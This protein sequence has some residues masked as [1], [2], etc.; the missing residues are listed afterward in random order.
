[1]AVSIDEGRSL[2]VAFCKDYPAAAQLRFAVRNSVQELYGAHEKNVQNMLG[3]YVTGP[4]LNPGQVHIVCGQARDTLDLTATLRNEILGHF[5]LNT[6]TGAEKRSV[7][8]ALIEARDQPVL[9]NLWA[10][11]DLHYGD[12]SKTIRAEEVFA[13]YCEGI[14]PLDHVERQGI[15]ER[16]AFALRETCVDHNRSLT[17]FDLQSL[18][19]MVA[20]G[21]HDGSRTQQNFPTEREQFQQGTRKE[22]RKSFHEL[23]AE[24]LIEQMKAG[25]APWQKPWKPG[26]PNTNIPINPTTGRRYRG[27]NAVNLMA[28]GRS[29]RRWMT[30]NQAAA[31]DAQVRKGEKGTP[32]Q[33]WKVAEE[34]PKVDDSGRPMLDEDGRPVLE[35]TAF[36]RPRVFFAT[37]FNAEQIDGLPAIER[38]ETVWDPIS[39]AEVILGESKAAIVHGERDRAF[40]R[41]S[42]DQI[43]LPHRA[44]FPTATNYYATALHELGHWTGH[45]Q[46]L[47]RDLAHPFGSDGYA[48]EE[49]RAEIASMMLGDQ[50]G[51]GHDP[52]QHA[53]YVASWVRA[54]QN[55][56]LEIVRAAAD[57]EKIQEFI[58]AF[59]QSRHLVESENTASERE[60]QVADQPEVKEATE[61]NSQVKNKEGPEARTERTFIE[62][63]FGEKEEAKALGA[64]WD[65]QKRS[66]YIPA[67]MPVDLFAKWQKHQDQHANLAERPAPASARKY[68]AVPF[69]ERK[70]AKAVGALW[71]S[72]AKSW[73]VGLDADLERLARW[74]P[75]AATG[76]QAPAMSPREEFAEALKEL[77][78]LPYSDPQASHPIMDGRPHR[79]EVIGDR[80]GDRA[81]FYVGHNDGHPAGFIKNNRSGIEIVWKSKGYVLGSTQQAV[82]Q[83]QAAAKAAARAQDQ[84][85]RQERVAESVGAQLGE[86]VEPGDKTPYLTAKGISLHRGIFT[87]RRGQVTYVPAFDELGKHWTTQYI[88]ADGTKRFAKGGRKEGCFHPVG[89]MEAIVAAPAIVIAEGYATAA[90]ITEALGFGAVAAFDAGNLKAVAQALHG[91]FPDKAIVIAGDDDRHL[92]MTLGVNSGRAKASEAAASVG[93][94]TVFPVFAA[95]EGDW[96]QDLPPIT[97]RLY[98]EQLASAR[99][100]D[101]SGA[102]LPSGPKDAG[103]VASRT[104]PLTS[105]Q[106]GALKQM[107]HYTDFNDLGVKSR[108]GM[109][110]V[111]RQISLALGRALR[112]ENHQASVLSTADQPVPQPRR[113]KVNT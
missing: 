51:I 15:L 63:P 29:D 11:V 18:V 45:P 35:T 31:V 9:R 49:L 33:Y 110:G 26:E 68:L 21:L 74:E 36:E 55:D 87:D 2:V 17:I 53:S 69:G 56:P 100:D 12:R 47:D 13:L 73:Y 44:Q 92:L 46:R 113:L 4:G 71:D 104:S 85:I 1:V 108:V 91:R 14:E 22:A 78:C 39:R 94:I 61:N 50:L 90:Q 112:G 99:F 88:Q 107:K 48:K 37:V 5:G 30:Y 23:V 38:E 106:L 3:G 76:A 24:R 82:L 42:T 101:S 7:I 80:K 8:D 58:L 20:Q 95:G 84:R 89:G 97:P 93:G 96:P 72:A 10:V 109:E 27:I 52:G 75:G 32:I 57:A 41:P 16:G 77:G 81:G 65:R 105:D 64:R 103:E 6:F 66:W 60:G 98:A 67:A 111:R 86:L 62:V 102:A 28:Q 19:L 40:Y 83:A 43:H 25:T 59:E 79:I 54:L 70:A 34:A